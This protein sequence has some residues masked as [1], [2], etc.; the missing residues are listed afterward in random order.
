MHKKV[1]IDNNNNIKY[2]VEISITG[3]YKKD[4]INLTA[5]KMIE[6]FKILL[7]FLRAYMIKIKDKEMW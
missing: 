4:E 2:D 3:A 6:R 7:L 5:A 1:K